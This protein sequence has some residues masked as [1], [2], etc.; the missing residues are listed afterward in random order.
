MRAKDLLGLHA[1][2]KLARQD[3]TDEELNEARMAVEKVLKT[4]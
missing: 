1:S 4:L 3:G 2:V